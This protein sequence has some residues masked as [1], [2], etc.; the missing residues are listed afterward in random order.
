MANKREA[1]VAGTCSFRVQGKRPEFW[2][3]ESG[4]VQLAAAWQEKD[5][6]TRVPLYL[7]PAES[8]FVVFRPA[9]GGLDPVVAMTHDG[10]SFPPASARAAA[11][12]GRRGEGRLRSARRR[13]SGP[14]T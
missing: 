6:V 10:K 2:W 9:T 5:G 4:R 8:V 3:P 14:A 7:E 13:R 11:A 12:E 1:A